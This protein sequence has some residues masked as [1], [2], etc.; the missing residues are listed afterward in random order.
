MTKKII[1]SRSFG[2][3]YHCL[4]D[5]PEDTYT[6]C[7]DKGVVLGNKPYRTAFFE[8]FPKEPKTFIRGEG[9]TVE[10]AEEKAWNKYQSII[11]CEKHY[12]NRVGNTETAV[13]HLCNLKLTQYYPP[14]GSCCVCGKEHTKNIIKSKIYCIDHFLEEI[15][16]I[17]KLNK[18]EN[19]LDLFN[20]ELIG[21]NNN[22]EEE[23]YLYEE[24]LIASYALKNSFLNNMEEHEKSNYIDEMSYKFSDYLNKIVYK[25]FKKESETT[26]SHYLFTMN[27]KILQIKSFTYNK[28]LIETILKSFFE[29]I[30][31]KD[32]DLVIGHLKD[33]IEMY[34]VRMPDEECYQIIEKKNA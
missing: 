21:E 20:I 5:W 13:C 25:A 18:Y 19:I 17:N 31:F 34:K 15:Q 30:E 3:G 9:Q 28:K 26:G 12:F 16:E 11:N 24:Y 1:A 29:N 33:F 7:G 27:A 23:Y 22:S 2:E 10:E 32:L 14:I 6:Q 4:K 8:A